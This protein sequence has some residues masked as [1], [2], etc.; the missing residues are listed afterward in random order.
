MEWLC[1]APTGTG[2]LIRLRVMPKARRTEP[3]GLRGDRLA[4]RVQAPPV[5]GQANQA[6][7]RWAAEAFG[8]RGSAVR[9]ARGEKSRE[10]DV[11][12]DGLTAERAGEIL[13][14]LTAHAK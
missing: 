9:L 4:L 12:I 14:A 8:V 3:E 11:A 13:S 6:V 2:V 10:K 1:I 5:E 7:L